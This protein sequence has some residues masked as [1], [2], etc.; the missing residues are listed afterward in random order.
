MRVIALTVLLVAASTVSDPATDQRRDGDGA[1]LAKLAGV[2]F[3]GDGL[4]S[5]CTLTLTEKGT[6]HFRR[7]GCLG[8]YEETE[9]TYSFQGESLECST[10]RQLVGR[11][12]S[13]T[14]TRLRPVDWSPRLYLLRD[15]E[16]EEFFEAVDRGWEPRSGRH[17]RFF[18]RI[19][20]WEKPVVGL[21]DLPLPKDW[22]PRLRLHEDCHG[23]AFWLT[24]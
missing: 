7:R 3:E 16:V 13:A 15:G 19:D 24:V 23:T 22:S 11:L 17:G 9:G 20:D 21:P 2:Y 14:P 18:L 1:A 12:T 6:F 4:G 8:L 5:N 10:T